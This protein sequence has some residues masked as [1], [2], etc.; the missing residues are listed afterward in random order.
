MEEKDIRGYIGRGLFFCLIAIY[1]F[2]PIPELL[3]AHNNIL[4]ACSV[5]LL[6]LLMV[7][8]SSDERPIIYAVYTLCLTSAIIYFIFT[9][10]ID[11]E[12]PVSFYILSSVLII[13]NIFNY[14]DMFWI[15]KENYYL[16][17]EVEN[18][19]IGKWK[20]RSDNRSD[21][22]T[23]YF[24]EFIDKKR[25]KSNG[26]FG[27]ENF[28]YK[29][30]ANTTSNNF[31]RI[32][33]F[34]KEHQLNVVLD[35]DCPEEIEEEECMTLGEENFFSETTNYMRDHYH[36]EEYEYPYYEFWKE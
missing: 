11:I 2:I 30:R 24:L 15:F 4:I 12:S 32:C 6:L 25:G 22:G 21:M 34:D 10:D 29:F 36:G 20:C 5:L 33:F 17:K 13:S 35:V 23:E 1:I 3:V 31:S 14:Y 28:T 9:K 16:S 18:N 19:I 7:R 8:I 26:F 27:L